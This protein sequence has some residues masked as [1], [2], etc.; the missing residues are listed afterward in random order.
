[1]TTYNVYTDGAVDRERRASA[2]AYI[3]FTDD[4]FVSL[5][6]ICV[7]GDNIGH[8]ETVAVGLACS[9]ILNNEELT[10]NEDCT[11]VFFIDCTST[12]G[13]LNGKLKSNNKVYGKAEVKNAVESVRNLNSRCNVVLKKADAH[14]YEHNCNKCVDALVKYALRSG[15]CMQS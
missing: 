5:N 9:D 3:A 6:Y 14:K 13:Y 11:F 2:S 8:A 10:L 7:E 12:I 4:K 15:E 1:M